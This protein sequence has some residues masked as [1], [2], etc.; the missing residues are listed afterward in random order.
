MYCMY[1]R[2]SRAD[3]ENEA[4]GEIETLA[5]HER[6]LHSVADSMGITVQ[7]VYREVVSGETIAS[8]PVVRKLL[9]EVSQ[10]IWEGVLV[11]EIERLARGDTI[12]QGVV[13]RTFKLSGTRIITPQKTF[14]PF[15]EFDEEYFEF[16]L[17]MS[18]REYKMINRRLQRGRIASV[19]EGKYV[20]NVAPL[21]YARKKLEGQ[22][23]Y[24]LMPVPEEADAVRTIFALF[25]GNNTD[26]SY[27]DRDMSI[28]QIVDTLNATAMRPR[29]GGKWT[30]STVRTVLANPVYIGKI[31][32]NTRP[33]KKVLTSGE[34]KITRPRNSEKDWII[35]EGKHE[36]IIDSSLFATAQDKLRKKQRAVRRDFELKNPLAGLIFCA[37]CGAKLTRRPHPDNKPDTLMCASKGCRCV[38]TRLEL[39]EQRL[40][41]AITM[42]DDDRILIIADVRSQEA[43]SKNIVKPDSRKTLKK[44]R[45][46]ILAQLESAHD[47]LE[48]GVY[49]V[50]TFT[51]RGSDLNR[52]LELINAAL[53]EDGHTD[54][55]LDIR[56]NGKDAMSFRQFVDIYMR[57]EKCGMKNELLKTVIEK[58]EYAKTVNGRWHDSPDNFEV[59]VYLREERISDKN[60]ARTNWDTLK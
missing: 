5:R 50:E 53:Q 55:T 13:A 36:A 15:N 49:S 6:T 45:D 16:G 51:V 59:T 24:S 39:V 2:K 41:S 27:A 14:D 52:R 29:N 7:A 42:L 4:R 10:E 37:L 31:R 38:S 9:D 11:V 44:E 20:A 40:L 46:A 48:K 43:I 22:K 18:R 30:V 1:L 57:L 3:L 32:W 35:T 12:D 25:A 60:E 47:L 33:Q 8:R 17:F 28:P 34:I 19:I 26:K 54:Q 56:A 23:G 21:G 58:I